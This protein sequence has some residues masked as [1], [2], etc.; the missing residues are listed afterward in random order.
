MLGLL[1]EVNCRRG[2]YGSRR[3]N[4]RFPASRPAAQATLANQVSAGTG[5]STASGTTGGD[6]NDV[7]GSGGVNGQK[8]FVAQLVSGMLGG[9]VEQAVFLCPSMC[10]N[11][12]NTM[13]AVNPTIVGIF[14]GFIQCPNAC[15]VFD[16]VVQVGLGVSDAIVE[17]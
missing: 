7:A 6:A 15:S 17:G 12:M 14:Q 5:S 8:R 2:G 10:E 13:N 9:M 16:S 11:L 1:V 3:P 4:P